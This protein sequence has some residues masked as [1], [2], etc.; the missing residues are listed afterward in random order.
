MKKRRLGGAA[1]LC[2]YILSLVA[3]QTVYAS[4]MSVSASQAGTARSNGMTFLSTI[5]IINSEPRFF[6]FE[7]QGIAEFGLSGIGFSSVTSAVMTLFDVP[8]IMTQGY[9]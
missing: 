3:P 1:W 5:Q 2:A 6:E 9:S 4:T 7:D 8:P